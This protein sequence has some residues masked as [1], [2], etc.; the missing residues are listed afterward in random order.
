MKYIGQ[1]KLPHG[2]VFHYM[3]SSGNLESNFVEDEKSI[4]IE[5]KKQGV[6]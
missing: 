4:F 1:T 5:T 6:C 2:T 3:N